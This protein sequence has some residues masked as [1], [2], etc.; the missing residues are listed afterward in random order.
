M[1]DVGKEKEKKRK[2]KNQIKTLLLIG[3]V[4]LLVGAE[5]YRI[6]LFALCSNSEVL[7]DWDLIHNVVS[8]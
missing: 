8:Q 1:E 4:E 5:C 2:K 7:T 6:F 3:G